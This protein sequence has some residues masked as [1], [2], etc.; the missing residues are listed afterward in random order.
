MSEKYNRSA[1]VTASAEL[2][3]KGRTSELLEKLWEPFAAKGSSMICCSVGT[4]VDEGDE[5]E[6][7]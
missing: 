3:S 4:E 2:I 1:T 6:L 5:G 7:R